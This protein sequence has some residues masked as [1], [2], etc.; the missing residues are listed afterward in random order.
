MESIISMI[1]FGVVI[2][3]LG[4]FNM[5]GNVSSIHWYHRTRIKKEDVKKYG[6][7]MGIGTL[8]IGISLI[9]TGLLQFFFELDSIDFIL[10]ISFI[11]GLVIFIYAQ[12]KYNK[13][14]F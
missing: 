13:G 4:I 2:S 8:L 1:V 9:V 12:F 11:I 7:L 3:V 6:L 14:I 10:F 5:K